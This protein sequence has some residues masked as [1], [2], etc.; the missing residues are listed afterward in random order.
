MK[1]VGR[2]VIISEL[3]RGAMGIVYQRGRTRRSTARLR[4]KVLSL[5]SGQEEEPTA[6]RKCSCAKFVPPAD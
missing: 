2:Y 6:R 1:K 4:S 5:N 3:G